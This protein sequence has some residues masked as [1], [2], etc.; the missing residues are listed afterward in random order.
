MKS[1]SLKN[2]V[3]SIATSLVALKVFILMEDETHPTDFSRILHMSLKEV[4]RS[5]TNFNFDSL[6]HCLDILEHLRQQE[7][8]MHFTLKENDELAKLFAKFISKIVDILSSLSDPQS[9]A[10]YFDG[11][12]NFFSRLL[13]LDRDVA[14]MLEEFTETVFLLPQLARSASALNYI[15]KYIS[16][17][18]SLRSAEIII[19]SIFEH[20][21]GDLKQEQLEYEQVWSN[22]ISR[23]FFS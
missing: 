20:F 2:K 14:C 11:I 1:T 22:F 12:F 19:E 21:I 18:G 6:R 23:R 7:I 15:R 5:F 8:V 13:A 16:F 9:R 4:E 10:V 3:D 17:N